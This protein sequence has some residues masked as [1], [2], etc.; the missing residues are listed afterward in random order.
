MIC[1]RRWRGSGCRRS[2]ASA[3]GGPA[4]VREAL[5]DCVEESERVLDILNAL[6]DITEAETGHDEAPEGED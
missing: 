3:G 6:M 5:A 2:G 4:A 1:G